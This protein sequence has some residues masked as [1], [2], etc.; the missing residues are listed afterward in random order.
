[1]EHSR[2]DA[3]DA[4]DGGSPLPAGA[5]LA[6]PAIS[7]TERRRQIQNDALALFAAK[8][9]RA[10]TIRELARVCQVSPNTVYGWFGDIDGLYRQSVEDG[11]KGLVRSIESMSFDSESPRDTIAA[12]AGWTVR[13]FESPGHRDL[14]YIVVRDRADHGWLSTAYRQSVLEPLEARLSKLVRAAGARIQMSLDLDVGEA[15]TLI[16]R[17]FADFAM[18]RLLPRERTLSSREARTLLDEAVARAVG[19]VREADPIA[20]SLTAM[21]VAESRRSSAAAG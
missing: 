21:L 6:S 5:G 4:R 15:R 19:A 1:M 3:F 14:L 20:V 10:V 12:F 13:L 2:G 8:S 18:P 11:L 9:P 16:D 17:L 7:S